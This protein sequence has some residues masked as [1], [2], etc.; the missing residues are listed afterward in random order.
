MRVLNI[1]QGFSKAMIISETTESVLPLVALTE[2]VE[3][4]SIE[5]SVLEPCSRCSCCCGCDRRW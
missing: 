2:A 1:P 3:D 5:Q 4:S